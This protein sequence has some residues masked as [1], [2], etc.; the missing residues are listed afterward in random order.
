MNSVPHKSAEKVVRRPRVAFVQPFCSHYTEGLFAILAKR[1]D[2]HFYFYSQGHEWFWQR[3]HGIRSG[4]FPHEYLSGFHVGTRRFTPTLPWKLFRHLADVILSS[5]DGRFSLPTAYLAARMKRVPFLLWTGLWFRIETPFHRAMF[6]LVRFVYRHADGVI[7]YGEHVKQYLITEGVSPDRIFVAA[8]SVDN[9]FYSRAV[10][11][12]EKEKLRAK[13][14][15][16]AK[17]KVVLYL[18]R[19]EKVKGVEYLIEAFA[20][21]KQEE[22]ILVIVGE[23]SERPILEEAVRNRQIQHRVRFAGY[24]PVENTVPYYAIASVLVLPSVNLPQGRETWGLVVNEAFNQGVPVIATEAVGA[25]AGGLVRDGVNGM[26]VAER[27][28]YAL[29]EAIKRILDDPEMR[30]RMGVEARRSIE[31]WDHVRCA[32]GFCRA[33]LSVMQRRNQWLAAKL[34]PSQELPAH[35]RE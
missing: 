19:L 17:Q 14:A 12:A 11:D 22:T 25:A 30:E 21:N 1:L 31:G 28:V 6:P 20:I 35:S 15:I 18:G 7:V 4:D 16:G 9:S 29:A 8:Q 32:E 13:L 3:E 5:I 10:T 26:V 34:P 24:T 27:N 2:V 33:I 23:G